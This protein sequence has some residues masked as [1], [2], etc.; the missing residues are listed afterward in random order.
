MELN[1]ISYLNNGLKIPDLPQVVEYKKETKRKVTFLIV[2]LVAIILLGTVVVTIGPLEI[3]VKEAYQAIG[4]KMF[5]RLIE[6]PED[7]VANAVWLVRIPRFLAGV[8]IGCCL[9]ISGAVMQPVLRNPMASPFTLGV[10]SGAGFGATLTIIVGWSIGKGTWL[11]VGNAFIFSMATSIVIL[12]QSKQKSMT[13]TTMILTGVAISYFFSAATSLL[14]YFGEAMATQGVVFWLMGSLAKGTWDTLKFIFP[15]FLVC[16]PYLTYKARDL[17]LIGTGDDTATALGVNVKRTRISLMIIASFLTSAVICFTGTIGFVGLVAPHI[18]RI[19]IGSDNRFVIPASGLLGGFM[20]AFSDTIAMN[21][22]SPVILPVG[23][24]TS[25]IG[26][27]IFVYL[28]RR[29][30]GGGY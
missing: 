12:M 20:L 14:Q 11:V 29:M 18:T 17:N 3:S 8:L 9:A 24:M 28:I 15:V 27:P 2:V 16:V 23:I 6:A 1:K 19:I 7:L 25:F 10:S 13:P 30:K 21:I 26:V 5:P 4:N 22:I